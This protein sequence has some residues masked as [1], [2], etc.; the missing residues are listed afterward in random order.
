MVEKR[1][2]RGREELR[3]LKL[4]VLEV[5]LLLLRARRE[6][7]LEERRREVKVRGARWVTGLNATREADIMG[8]CRGIEEIE[9]I[10][11]EMK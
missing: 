11:I 8:G 6:E 10:G 3:V 9:T 7:G 1:E 4:E 2:T 5:L